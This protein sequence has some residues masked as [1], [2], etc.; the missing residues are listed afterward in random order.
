MQRHQTLGRLFLKRVHESQ[1]RPAIGWID[2]HE[3]KSFSYKEYG[4]HVEHLSLG[5]MKLGLQ[6]GDKL[7]ILSQTCKEWHFM[8]IAT[9]CSRAVVIPIYP[10]YL[11]DDV[12]YIF[13]HSD[14]SFLVIENDHQFEKIVSV[15]SELPLLKMII[16]IHDISEENKKKI[17]FPILSYKEVLSEGI[18][19]LKTNPDLF[20][21]TIKAQNSDEIASII[22]TSGTTGEP[23]GAVITHEALTTMLENVRHFVQGAFNEND[24]TLTFLPLSHVL[25][26]CD[27]FLPIVFGW[28]TIF[29]ESLEKIVNNIALVKPTIMVAV[30]RIF[31]KIYEKIWDQV[32]AG[33]FAKKQVFELAL[34]SAR[35]Y[36]EKIDADRSPSAFEIISFKLAQ[37]AVFS[38]IYQRFG[39]KI[40]FFVSGGAPLSSEIIQFL[41]FSGLTILEGYGLT[42]TIAPC[43]LNPLSRQKVGTVGRPM[44]DVSIK[45]AT[46]GEI[47]IKTKAL[48][49]GYYKNPEATAATMENEWFHSGDIGHFTQDG[50]LK[51]TD[52]KKD[53]II[54]SG[55]KNVAPQK[56]ENM[57]KTGK[58]ISQFVVIGDNR[59]FLTAL[60]GIEKERFVPF[61]TQWGL[62]LDTSLEVLS[63]RPEVRELIQRDIDAINHD[64]PQYETIKNFHVLSEELSMQNYLTPSLKIKR[65]L[66]I[67][68][69]QKVIEKMYE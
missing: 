28:H 38:K 55:G 19:H 24:R 15:I 32:D 11:S 46:D 66:I 17:S 45:F 7:A 63:A 20:E 61:F 62:A 60:V 2:N 31:E 69:Y 6:T 25:G 40:R 48:F 68:D 67:Q 37:E 65:K 14:S 56:I 49:S 23:K 12:K 10:S 43:V 54:T 42:E 36:F 35:S 53:I 51:I 29:A 22:Y 41:R 4:L 59:K 52:R 26:R 64:L 3:I 30:P 50:Y 21:N 33:G 8:D 39:G 27:S 5:L 58:Y 9:L 16:S 57:M 34:K 18:E 13:N 47:L 44:G 1:V